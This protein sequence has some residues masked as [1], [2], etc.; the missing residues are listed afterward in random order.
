MWNRGERV[1]YSFEKLSQELRWTVKNNYLHI[2]ADTD[3]A[4]W[5]VVSAQVHFETS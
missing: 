1:I 4:R 3:R 5:C 2:M